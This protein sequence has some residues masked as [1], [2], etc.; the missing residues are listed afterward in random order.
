MRRDAALKTLCIMENSRRAKRTL[1]LIKATA[2]DAA[3]RSAL[4][5]HRFFD[6]LGES[7]RAFLEALN[8]AFILVGKFDLRRSGRRLLSS[9]LL[10]RDARQQKKHGRN[11]CQAHEHGFAP[12]LV[13]P[14]C[15]RQTHVVAQSIPL[16]CPLMMP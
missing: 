5:L 14:N 7:V 15:L 1:N 3:V 10:R 8:P 2:I 13:H 4:L 12:Q 6:A 16:R 11:T 9:L